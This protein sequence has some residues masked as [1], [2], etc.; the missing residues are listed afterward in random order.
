MRD[1][2][3]LLH[4]KSHEEAFCGLVIFHT[5]VIQVASS[6]ILVGVHW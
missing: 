6:V 2:S 5:L 1:S 3:E 4:G